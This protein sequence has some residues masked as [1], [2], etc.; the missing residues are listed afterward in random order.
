MCVLNLE[1]IAYKLVIFTLHMLSHDAR[2]QYSINTI[3]WLISWSDLEFNRIK[4]EIGVF[5]S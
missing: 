5:E 4:M 3:V 1:D 2:F